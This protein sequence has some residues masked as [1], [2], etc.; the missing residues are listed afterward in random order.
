MSRGKLAYSFNRIV[1]DK[2]N[3]CN[4]YCKQLVSF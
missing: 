1:K 4:D 3:S 2:E